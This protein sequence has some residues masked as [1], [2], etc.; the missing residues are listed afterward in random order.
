MTEKRKECKEIYWT[1]LGREPVGG[2][3]ATRVYPL[4]AS[5]L[6]GLVGVHGPFCPAVAPAGGV[7][8]ARVD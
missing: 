5:P 6:V 8:P 2:A 3:L 7:L 4:D 1:L